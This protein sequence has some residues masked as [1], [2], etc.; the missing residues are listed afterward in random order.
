VGLPL[1]EFGQR[2]TAATGINELME[3]LGQ[4]FAHAGPETVMM[5]GGNPAHIPAVEAIWR[6]RLEEILADPAAT[7]VM[8][9]DYDGP[10]GK[11]R[12]LETF[13]AYLRRTRG[14]E[15]GPENVAI[16]A[17]SQT[18]SFLLLNMLAGPSSAARPRRILLPLVPEYIGYADQILRDGA[19][20]ACQPTI[21]NRGPHRFKYHVDFDAL[22]M[23]DD[24]AAMLL[25]RPTNPS[26]NVV[27]DAEVGRL[28]GLAREHGALLIVDNA[29]GLP[30]PGVVFGEARLPAWDEHC[31]FTFS[32]SK[33]GLPGTR[34]GIV[35][36]SAEIIRRL[37]AMNA[38]VGLANGTIG[39][40]MTEPLFA[41]GR[42]D[43]I[44]A[45]HN[46]PYY[47]Q[48]V[49]ETLATLD[50]VLGDDVDWAVHEPE[51]A[52]FLWLWFRN[53]PI[54][55]R[56]LYGRLKAR[57]VIAVPGSYFFYGLERDWPHRRQCLRLSYGQPQERVRRGLEILAEVVR[58]CHKR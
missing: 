4:A 30:F 46:R 9:G 51:G 25:S 56:E 41:S 32:L 7:A 1:S 31:V 44:S 40:V 58:G 20:V 33:L 38:V 15:V 26:A 19:F 45:E 21:E 5:G 24:V 47:T 53:L 12:F 54:D 50:E 27:T 57:G 23:S 14:W 34:T 6:Q 35:V 28:S 2:L 8:L 36:A 29:Y 52:F 42:I 13:A 49:R 16:T 55:D 22:R 3:D 48:R 18:G 39:Q 37:S 43:H 10:Q 11:P 17:G